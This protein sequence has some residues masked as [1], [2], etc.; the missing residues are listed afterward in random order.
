LQRAQL[1]RAEQVVQ[2]LTVE[3]ASTKDALQ[4]ETFAAAS[5]QTLADKFG[6]SGS[7]ENLVSD[8]LAALA[9]HQAT[10]AARVEGELPTSAMAVKDFLGRV[11]A[12]ASL[13][14]DIAAAAMRV[15]ADAWS[16]NNTALAQAQRN[17]DAALAALQAMADAAPQVAASTAT[18]ARLAA[19]PAPNPPVSYS[20]LTPWQHG[21]LHDSALRTQR[22]GALQL[23]TAVDTARGALIAP[24]EAYDKALHGAQRGEP[25]KTV[26]QLDATTL[27]AERGAL[28]AALAALQD[29]RDDYMALAVTDREALDK[30]FAAV[31][32][33]LW[34]ALDALDGATGR[35]EKI[36]G[37][38]TPGNL[39]LALD[40]AE[41]ALEAALRA[42]RE[43]R[44]QVL[45][46]QF[47]L[48]GASAG[49]R[50]ALDSLAGG[51][52]AMAHS[53]AL[54]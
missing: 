20:I 42:D 24:Q 35:L 34:A 19:L 30:W 52:S 6:A 21:L 40:N 37:S 1:Q 38:P 22:E 32:D 53:S 47:A 44:R 31:P 43:A 9:V 23:L 12:R 51:A 2:R 54:F 45:G 5:R 25:D 48:L 17:F 27:S 15:E 4:K 10:A 46:G 13:V 11:R 36:G 49:L 50:A 3:L 33:N 18:L 28:D 26:A 7:L 29:A 14:R 8:A 41:V 16:A 39:I